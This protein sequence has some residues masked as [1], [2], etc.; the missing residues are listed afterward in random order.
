MR[1]VIY[2]VVALALGAAVI[3]QAR[4]T[5]RLKAQIR[6]SARKRA[7]A[8]NEL[9]KM[10]QNGAEDSDAPNDHRRRHLRIVPAVATLVG[11]ATAL[12]SWAKTHPAP[13]AAT[14]AAASG[15]ALA[16]LLST[17][18]PA[19]N[20]MPSPPP[21]SPHRSITPAPP[22]GPSSAPT[23]VRPP[24]NTTSARS[25]RTPPVSPGPV[26][27]GLPTTSP[28]GGGATSTTRPTSSNAPTS[29][30]TT[31]STTTGTSSACLI[32][33]EVPWILDLCVG[34]HEPV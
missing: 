6:E 28:S 5:K 2:A 14:V 10:I 4:T 32:A 23:P 25:T 3:L 26:D 34:G 13:A 8:H 15:I 17:N 9:K 27:R 18:Q 12:I 11:V 30:T 19:D 1:D 7:A 20:A 16:A 22:P 31:T 21:A 33:I 29:S 24:V